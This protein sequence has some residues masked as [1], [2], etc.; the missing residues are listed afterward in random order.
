MKKVYYNGSIITLGK[1]ENAEAVLIENG[2][3]IEVGNEAQIFKLI[4]GEE[5]EKV[6][7]NGKCL[8]PAFIDSHSHIT[9]LAQTLGIAQLEKCS[10]F[11]DII[12][13]MKKFK[14][15]NNKNDKEWLIGFGYDHNLLEE[16]MHPTKE[17]LDQ[18]SKE[19]PIMITHQ[20]GHMGVVNTK[21]L[22]ILG[23]TENTKSPEGGTIG[24]EKGT[25]MPNGYLE[26]I[27]FINATKNTINVTNEQMM[28]QIKRAEKI[29]ASFGI[30]TVQ[31]GLTKEK[32][33]TLLKC[34]AEK[35]MLD[36]DIVS[37]VDIKNSKEIVEQNKNFVK[38]YHQHYKIGGYKLFL[39]G[40]P[41]GKTACMSK[42][43]EGETEYRGYPIYTNEEVEKYVKTSIEEKMQLITH[44]NGDAAAEQLIEAYE[45]QDVENYYRPVMIHA[46]LVRH[47]QLKRMKKI[48]MI[49]SFFVAHVYYWGDIHIKNF[50]KRAQEISPIKSAIEENLV[51][52]MHQDTPVIMPNMFETIWCAVTRTTKNGM[53]LGKNQKITVL[54]AIKGVTI[55]A[56]YQ[57]FEENEKGSIEKGKSADF[58][59][60]DKNPLEIDMDDI[61]NIKIVYTIKNGQIIYE[62]KE[63]E[64]ARTNRSNEDETKL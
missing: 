17:I 29:Y 55:N 15:E 2:K 64:H 35:Q 3:I 5:V 42:P 21:A 39:D 40:S 49:P 7:L 32:E 14:M 38:N 61:K 28:H 50:G 47:D 46:Q 34:M 37:Y 30:T 22:E 53:E 24:R 10:N 27:A 56:A 4:G 20:S 12:E 13:T 18:I 16:K 41:Q 31:D 57:Y 33:F 44:C 19:N 54:D 23:I 6:D 51:Y 58:I 11:E 36:L 25:Q 60:I 63:N 62:N 26:E 43:Y 59:I 52:T 1:E 48:H 9:A 45:K 8:M